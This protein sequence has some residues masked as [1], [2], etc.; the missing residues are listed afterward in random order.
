MGLP[1]G[2]ACGPSA[3][4]A[5]SERSRL[6]ADSA[7]T[8]DDGWWAWEDLNL[9]LHP[10]TKIARVATGS[11]A[12]RRAELGRAARFSS[13]VAAP[14]HGGLIRYRGLTAVRTLVFPG[15]LRPSGA[16]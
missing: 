13:L 15:H 16:K 11:V 10:E 3:A 5:G 12:P 8:C 6:A 14:G 7:L 2:W 9:R 1:V 4:Q